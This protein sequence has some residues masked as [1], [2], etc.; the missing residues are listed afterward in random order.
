MLRTTLLATSLSLAT[1]LVGCPAAE[2]TPDAAATADAPVST[3]D[4]PVSTSD[5]PA[6][7]RPSCDALFIACHDADTGSGPAHECHELGH[8]ES[9]TEAA[10]AA[11][12]TRCT[13][14]CEAALAVDAGP[15]DAGPAQDAPHAH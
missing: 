15:F 2:V 7:A 10:C 8:E 1:A 9:T 6:S 12:L 4:A 13:M 11:E 5:A 14:L 3:A